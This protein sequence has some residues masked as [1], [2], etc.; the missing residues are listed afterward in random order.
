MRKYVF[1]IVMLLICCSIYST[2]M[3]QKKFS[4]G[5][6]VYD[7]TLDPPANHEGVSQYTGSYVLTI[8][9]KQLKK[10]F[11]LNNGFENIMIY[12]GEQV[13]YSIK[14]IGNKKY[15]IQL[16]AEAA[17]QPYKKYENGKLNDKGKSA[18]LLGYDT[19]KGVMVYKDGS[20]TE[21]TYSA[22]IVA[23]V[24]VFER[25]PDMQGLPM[26]FRFTTDDGVI[27]H[28]RVRE[29]QETPV[30]SITFKVPVQYKIITNEEFQKMR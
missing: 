25:F 18:P 2:A 17:Q 19:R 29:I 7:V 5:R 30:E 22:D 28:F 16:N 6:I 27:L 10:E 11:S 20:N 8:K 13:V 15:A 26:D 9:N 3:A 23:T 24:Q 12:P 1:K 14:N 21:V 4:E